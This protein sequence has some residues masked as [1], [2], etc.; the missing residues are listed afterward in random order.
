[1][2]RRRLLDLYFLDARHKLV[3][4]AAFLDRLD[5]A[6]GEEDFRLEAFRQALGTL[7]RR[8]PDRAG[9]VLRIFSD[10]TREPVDPAPP[11]PACGAWPPPP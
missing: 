6:Q 8:E 10:P 1:M 7:S 3:D 4:L 2:T 11:S 5:R 9:E